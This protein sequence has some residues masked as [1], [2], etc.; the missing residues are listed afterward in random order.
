MK[1]VAF[2]GSNSSTS[3]NKQLVEFVL[4]YFQDCEINLLDLNEYEMPIFSVDREKS[5][6]P[7]E[8]Q[9]FLEQISKS[10]II[11]CSMAEH[12]KTYSVAFKNIF[13]WCSRIQLTVFQDKPMFL[14]STSP[15]GF[16]GGN[17][18]N[19]AKTFFPRF[20]AD[21]KQTFSLP[22]FDENFN[23]ID[24]ITEPE[25]LKELEEKIQLF[26]VEVK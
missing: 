7:K 8:A 18:M 2:A 3:R 17:V 9:L 19:V 14:M 10:D 12:N 5:G 11:I 26:N 21:I 4:Q 25:L 6:Y 24:G 13:D 16:G 15:G 22:K 20:G 23:K 1:I